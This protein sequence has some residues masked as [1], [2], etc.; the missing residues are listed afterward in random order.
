[1]YQSVNSEQLTKATYEYQVKIGTFGDQIPS[2]DELPPLTNEVWTASTIHGVTGW[3][4]YSIETKEV[5]SE[6]TINVEER[7]I[8]IR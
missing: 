2:I 7:I 5:K 3:T 6:G 1:M 4:T 8:Q